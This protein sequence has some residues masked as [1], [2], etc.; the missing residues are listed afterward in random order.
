MTLSRMASIVSFVLI[1]ISVALLLTRGLNFGI[2]F[3]GGLLM[4]INTGEAADLNALRQSLSQK[5]NKS[6]T[7][8][9][10][11]A[12]NEVLIRVQADESDRDQIVEIIRASL[13]EGAVERRKEFVGASVGKD[14]IQ[15]AAWAVALSLAAML[16]Y[17]W[18]RF[19]WQFGIGAIAALFHDVI[20]TLGFF[21]LT[22]LEFNLS[23]IAAILTI[24]GY[25]INDTVVVFDRVRES[26][27]KYNTKTLTELLNISLNE[28]LSRT[29]LTSCTTLAALLCLF[30]FGGEIIRGFSAALLLGV[31]IGTWSSLFVAVPTLKRLSVQ[32]T[33]FNKHRKDGTIKTI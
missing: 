6:I 2:D 22:Q 18:L 20:I 8:Q 12:D 1:G 25:S 31:V 23:T 28:T 15:Q 3:E 32:L 14:L 5:L 17:I 7:L 19:E 21:S 16:I 29:I 13:P 24:V 26:F 9:T 4:E 27:R 30:L 11:G 10:F 33:D